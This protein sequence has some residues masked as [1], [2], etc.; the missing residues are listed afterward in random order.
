MTDHKLHFNWANH[1]HFEDALSKA[2]KNNYNFSATK[3]ELLQILK[4][5]SRMNL[6][7]L[8]FTEAWKLEPGK[9]V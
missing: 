9:G 1:G 8:K 2:F 6:R 7:D 4:S 3:T 5:V